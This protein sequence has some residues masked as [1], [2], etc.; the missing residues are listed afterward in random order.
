MGPKTNASTLALQKES[1]ELMKRT[2]LRF[3]AEVARSFDEF[4]K[5]GVAIR[6]SY[7][8]QANQ[9]PTLHFRDPIHRMSRPWDLIK[10]RSTVEVVH[11][12]PYDRGHPLYPQFSPRDDAIA[13]GLTPRPPEY[14]SF[15]KA[16]PNDGVF[17]MYAQTWKDDP[18][19][20][21]RVFYNPQ[22]PEWDPDLQDDDHHRF[23]TIPEVR[24]ESSEGICTKS[25]A[26]SFSMPPILNMS[27]R[28]NDRA[29]A[30]VTAEV[31]LSCLFWF[32]PRGAVASWDFA[33][34]RLEVR[35]V[36]SH[37]SRLYRDYLVVERRAD[38]ANPQGLF[39]NF[40]DRHR[41]LVSYESPFY[42]NVDIAV[43]GQLMVQVAYDSALTVGC[44]ASSLTSEREGRF[45]VFIP[46]IKYVYSWPGLE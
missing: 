29:V 15:A 17:D 12:A 5:A 39:E 21:N 9:S 19:L 11:R 32:L 1:E 20:T 23:V 38:S 6:N 2:D 33:R 10:D 31:D 7:E 8:S 35:L 34:A 3:L 37:A 24:C 16:V 4:H 27:P 14:Y 42:G 18:D 13:S 26:A 22:D 45:R 40:T 25:V 43:H 36:V 41:L 30:S 46:E 44:S 28:S